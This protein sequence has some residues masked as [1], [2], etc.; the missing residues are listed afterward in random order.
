MFTSPNSTSLLN[1]KKFY[2]DYFQ[3]IIILDSQLPHVATSLLTHNE[4]ALFLLGYPSGEVLLVRQSPT[5]QSISSELKYE[6]FMPR[7]ISGLAEKFR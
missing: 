6:S 1:L 2:I 4:E 3:C 5:G 7:F